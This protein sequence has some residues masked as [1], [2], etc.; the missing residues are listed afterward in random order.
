MLF[1]INEEGLQNSSTTLYH[2]L[3][4]TPTYQ[5]YLTPSTNN[6][7]SKS[8]SYGRPSDE[9]FPD[10]LNSTNDQ[11]THDEQNEPLRIHQSDNQFRQESS[12][13]RTE[14]FQKTE[15]VISLADKVRMAIKNQ[16]KEKIKK[17]KNHYISAFDLNMKMESALNDSNN[18][19][20]FQSDENLSDISIDRQKSDDSFFKKRIRPPTGIKF[21]KSAASIPNFENEQ[22]ECVSNSGYATPTSPNVSNLDNKMKLSDFQIISVAGQGAYGKVYKVAP[23]FRRYE[24]STFSRI[25][26]NSQYVES[27]DS[28]LNKGDQVL[29]GQPNN[30]SSGFYHKTQQNIG[31][32]LSPLSGVKYF[33]L[34]SIEKK[35]V[36]LEEKQHEVHIEKMVLSYLKNSSFIKFYQSFQDKTKLYFL[37]EYI[38]NG[39]LCDFLKSERKISDKLARHFVAEIVLG[40]QYLRQ[41]QVI[42]RDLKPGNLL[43]DE[44][45]HIKFIDFATSKVLNKDMKDRI[46]RKKASQVNLCNELTQE[47]LN[48]AYL[49]QRNY[50]MVGTEEY[51]APEILK[52]EEVTYATD[53]W[54]LGIIIYQMYTG[55]TPFKGNSEYV[56]FENILNQQDIDYPKSVPQDAKD[57]ISSLLKKN[58]E[59]RIGAEDIEEIKNHQYFKSIDFVTIKT[60]AVPYRP[61]QIVRTPHHSS[62][63]V[64]NP[65][66]SAQNQRKNVK[67]TNDVSIDRLGDDDAKFSDISYSDINCPKNL[68]NNDGDISFEM[69]DKFK[70]R[71]HKKADRKRSS[72][73]ND[74]LSSR[75]QPEE[76]IIILKRGQLK[77][78][79]LFFYN[80]RIVTLNALGILTYTDPKNLNQVRGHID[81]KDQSITTKIYGKMKDQFEII[82]K[83]GNFMFKELQKGNI[84]IQSWETEI[85][86]FTKIVYI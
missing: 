43:L 33:A 52:K 24:S 60:Q 71:P 58:P 15:N 18:L 29:I 6:S 2:N 55:K 62:S 7:N 74:S 3:Q 67:S 63:F 77:K 53:L 56:T 70:Q 36:Y 5:C 51:V 16:M 82:T 54:S 75:D 78:K 4:N 13:T 68:S 25:E 64:S 84:E 38:P 17:E 69:D 79:G 41:M 1:N 14:K 72:S 37:L 50:S 23:K 73:F 8:V 47:Q 22:S 61:I 45:Y 80:N 85:K 59:N 81:L 21:S 76:D 19:E 66:I 40:L 20:R 42:H 35:I 39:S 11:E 32:Q 86:K 28:N 10:N 83:Y 27:N 44:N 31:Q 57:L 12:V 49:D 34:K 30:S 65:D 26:Q 9:D 48:Q 46:P